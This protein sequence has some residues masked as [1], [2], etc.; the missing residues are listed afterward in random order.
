MLAMKTTFSHEEAHLF[1]MVSNPFFGEEVS[2]GKPKL[3][4]V[5]VLRWD[6]EAREWG[7]KHEGEEAYPQLIVLSSSRVLEEKDIKTTENRALFSLLFHRSVIQR[8]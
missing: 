5:C 3:L 2:W 4:A 1:E 8:V 6:I 7:M